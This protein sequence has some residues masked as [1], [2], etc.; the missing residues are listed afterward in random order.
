VQCAGKLRILYTRELEMQEPRRIK[1]IGEHI[2]EV[3]HMKIKNRV[4]IK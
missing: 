1:G 3:S 2:L 4:I